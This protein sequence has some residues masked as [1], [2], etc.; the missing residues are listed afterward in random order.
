MLT[1]AKKI[2]EGSSFGDSNNTIVV[3]VVR[4]SSE[5]LYGAEE[6]VLHAQKQ[7][8]QKVKPETAAEDSG[9]EGIA[10]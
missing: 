3:K 6:E 4:T 10:V 5:K 7:R 2:S 9:I 8:K 1:L